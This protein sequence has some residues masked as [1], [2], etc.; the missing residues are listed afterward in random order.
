MFCFRADAGLQR[1]R[2]ARAADARGGASGRSATAMP[3]SARCALGAGLPRRPEG[4]L[5]RCGDGAHRPRRRARGGLSPGPTSATGRRSGSR[6]RATPTASPARAGCTTRDVSDSYLRSDGRLV[7]VLGVEGLAVVDTAGRA[8][9][10]ADRPRAGGQGPGRRARGRR[11]RR[12]PARRRGSTGPG[13]G[14]R[15]SISARASG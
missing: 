1:D 15:P 13:A 7:C 5:R 9:D 3:I 4:Q 14:T 10:R 6:A 2:A 12:R 11:R 8:A